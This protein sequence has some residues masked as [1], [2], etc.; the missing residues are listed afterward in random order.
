[1]LQLASLEKRNAEKEEEINDLK[2]TIWARLHDEK[3]QK[4][5]SQEEHRNDWDAKFSAN[6]AHAKDLKD[7][8][9]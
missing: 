5:R 3:E 7:I 2:K 6:Q 4:T 9:T 8:L 1:M